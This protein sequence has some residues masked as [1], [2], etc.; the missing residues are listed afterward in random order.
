MTHSDEIQAILANGR[1][2]HD[3]VLRLRH[4]VFWKGVVTP[5]DADT[6]FALNDRLAAHCAP[7]WPEFFVEALTD[8]VVHQAEP[9]GYIS[10]A[11]AD[12][13][14]AC[15]SRSG[16]V[17]TATELE[18]L[19]RALEHA[20]LSP[21]ALVAFALEQVK[22]GVVEGKGALGRN[23]ALPPGV[24][25]ETEVDVVRR[26][27]YAFGGDGNIAVTRQEAEIL[28]DINDATAQADNH[29]T[30]P[31]LF[32]KALANFLMAA[33]GYRVPP[34]TEALR[35]AAWLDA[36]TPGIGAFMRQMLAGSLHAVWDGYEQVTRDAPAQAST[37]LTIADV[38]RVTEEEALWAAQRIG[39]DGRLHD[40][41]VALINFLKSR[42]AYLHPKL[43]PILD[44][45]A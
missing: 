39:C 19:V 11:N 17:D 12:W 41:E 4:R 24:V 29:P 2:A 30:W 10:D 8:Y 33:S 14:I 36:P 16:H 38:P 35:R 15:I 42:N 6:L 37:G 27:L 45:A 44:R 13:L 34:R 21:I 32:V 28:F 40:S 5:Q 26:I 43:L 7:S 20:K 9:S 3:D 25:E 22:W 31:D 1:I 18:I 23:R